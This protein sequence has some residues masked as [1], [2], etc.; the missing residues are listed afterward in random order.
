MG[1]VES[2]EAYRSRCRDACRHLRCRRAGAEALPFGERFAHSS[3]THR[4][5]GRPPAWG[6]HHLV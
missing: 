2:P 3:R 4:A 5:V 1:R 6:G